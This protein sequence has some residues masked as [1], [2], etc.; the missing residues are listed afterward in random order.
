MDLYNE[1]REGNTVAVQRLLSAGFDLRYNIDNTYYDYLNDA[2]R[3][4]NPIIVEML[5]DYGVEWLYTGCDHFKSAIQKGNPTIVKLL[6]DFGVRLDSGNDHLASALRMN[7]PV[8]VELLLDYPYIDP[9]VT[10]HDYLALAID[11]GKPE[12]VQMVLDHGVRPRNSTMAL[13]LDYT[14]NPNI[15]QILN[16]PLLPFEPV[17]N[18]PIPPFRRA[19]NNPL[20]RRTLLPYQAVDVEEGQECPICH[21]GHG[22]EDAGEERRW[23]KTVCG[24]VF[25]RTCLESWLTP[26]HPTCPNCRNRLA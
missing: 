7:D 4:N 2:I 6:L 17:L 23:V 22:D 11:G 13:Y 18:R 3:V 26:S 9:T 21:V 25:C 12:I 20:V 14:N 16:T 19:R 24:H 5:L 1:I 15:L 10:S 8:I